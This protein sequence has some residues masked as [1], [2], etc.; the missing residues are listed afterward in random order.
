MAIKVL[1]IDKYEELLRFLK[2]LDPETSFSAML[3]KFS[4]FSVFL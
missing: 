4:R 1:A 3:Q 2:Y